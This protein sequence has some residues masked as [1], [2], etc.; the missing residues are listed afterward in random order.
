MKRARLSRNLKLQKTHRLANAEHAFF[1]ALHR[2][3]KSVK[4]FVAE[5]EHKFDNLP[6]RTQQK[7]LT[8]GEMGAGAGLLTAGI[9]SGS[10]V[11]AVAGSVALAYM[12]AQGAGISIEELSEKYEHWKK[13]HSLKGSK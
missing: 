2:S 8:A 11:P 9:A 5:A 12:S 1:S 10:A 7:L 6:Y 13:A 3:G 4:S